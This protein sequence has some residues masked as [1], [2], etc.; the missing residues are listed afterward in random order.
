MVKL[1]GNVIKKCVWVINS[2]SGSERAE[3]KISNEELAWP[4]KAIIQLA[5]KQRYDNLYVVIKQGLSPLFP[6]G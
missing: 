2:R 4:S 6:V 3:R 5:D 1:L